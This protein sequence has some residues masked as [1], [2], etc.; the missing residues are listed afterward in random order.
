MTSDRTAAQARYDSRLTHE[1]MGY[2]NGKL[3][4]NVT[5]L[6]LNN[7]SKMSERIIK[8]ERDDGANKSPAWC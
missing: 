1:E 7:G 5:N 6:T 3:G 4:L 2:S 8:W